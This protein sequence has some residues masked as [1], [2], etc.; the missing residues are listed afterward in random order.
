[1]R[2][3]TLTRRIL[4]VLLYALLP[5][6]GSTF[7]LRAAQQWTVEEITLE[8]TAPLPET[9][10]ALDVSVVAEFTAPDG[11][12]VRVNGFWDG[13]R[14]W[15]VRFTP[16]SAGTWN[17]RISSAPAIPG[18]A[19]DGRLAVKAAARGARGF[20]RRDAEHPQSFSFDS[21]E[22]FFMWG[23]TVYHL[24]ATA[25]S[26]APWRAAL[27]SM[28]Q[29][30]LN[31]LRF[32]I[33][34]IPRFAKA[35]PH[36]GS[37][38]FID[39]DTAR[40]NLKHFRAVDE[41]IRACGEIGLLADVIVYPYI[42][43][44]DDDS[45]VRDERFR[46][47]VIARYAAFPHLMW[48]LT[49]EWNYS[50]YPQKFWNDLGKRFSAEDPWT[51]NPTTRDHRA[52]RALSIHQ[53]TRPDW[54]FA[55]ESWTSHAIIQLGVRNRGTTTRVGDEWNRAAE[56]GERFTF[57][58]DWGNHSIV[59]NWNGR[60]PIVNDEYGYIGE[61][62]DDSAG[63]G[64]DKGFLRF[65]REKHRRTAWAIAVG[66]GYGAAGDKRDFPEGR[67]YYSGL[68]Q[69][70]PDFDDLTRLIA[71]FTRGDV[72][73]WRMRPANDLAR[74]AARVY[75][76]ADPG[77]CYVVYAADGGKFSLRLPVGEF[78]AVRIDP[79]TGEENPLPIA[80]N[81]PSA[82]VEVT[83][84]AGEDWTVRISKRAQN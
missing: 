41:V 55:D 23:N 11:R 9:M 62:K 4:A 5:L 21:G 49:N 57:G 65:T 71:F 50:R 82:A 54:N 73:Y 72:P 2:Q 80:R 31:K 29:A 79:R 28:R 7:T 48:C 19:R 68:W 44:D 75:V 1:M 38:A 56:S 81:D 24:V 64:P 12:S 58:D 47:Y 3:S 83:L 52:P 32:H 6:A 59:R 61:P 26:D 76:L 33:G 8:A 84:P 34:S 16:T 53:Q 40:L 30:G 60:Y 14:T 17:Y 13:E 37:P 42:R 78:A 51:L 15:R 69:P 43:Q 77:N 18:L 35:G 27:A 74:G 45:N 67:P 22:R 20:L 46:R 10:P 66:G 36:P 39:N 63:R 25:Q 70:A